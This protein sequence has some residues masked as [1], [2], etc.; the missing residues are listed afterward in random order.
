MSNVSGCCNATRATDVNIFTGKANAVRWHFTPVKVSETVNSVSRYQGTR[1]QCERVY[2]GELIQFLWLLRLAP[3]QHL[4][5][6]FWE[7]TARPS[8]MCR[9]HHSPST[10]M[11]EST[12]AP[13]RGSSFPV[14]A[15]ISFSVSASSFAFDAVMRYTALANISAPGSNGGSPCA[16]GPV[17]ASCCNRV[18]S[19]STWMSR[20]IA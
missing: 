19:A 20:V 11:H 9:F 6:C 10:F 3:L 17:A 13:F 12:S 16:L 2:M 14:I 4:D 5:P 18:R 8:R 1:I 7:N 15:T